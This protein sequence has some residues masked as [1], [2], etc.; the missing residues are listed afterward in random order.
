MLDRLLHRSVVIAINGDSYSDAGPQVQCR[1]ASGFG[2][3]SGMIDIQSLRTTN[4]NLHDYGPPAI[5]CA[6]SPAIPDQ[7]DSGLEA[8]FP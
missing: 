4:S 8:A 3:P 1:Q 2:A 6:G 5:A 7:R